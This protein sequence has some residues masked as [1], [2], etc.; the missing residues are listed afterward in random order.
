MNDTFDYDELYHHGI[1]GQKWGVRRYRNKDGTL[2][3]LGKSRIKRD[4]PTGNRY[5]DEVNLSGKIHT[6]VARDY[7]SAQNGANGFAGASR[8]GAN[9]VREYGNRKREKVKRS[10]DVS[11]LSDKELE[12]RIRRMN[13]ERNY[14]SL[15]AESVAYGADYTASMLQTFGDIAAIGASLASIALAYHTIKS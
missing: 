14:R 8:S 7:K 11:Q 10:L 12:T 4:N 5:D 1:L 9:I 6:R 2:T 13:L 3:S 15:T